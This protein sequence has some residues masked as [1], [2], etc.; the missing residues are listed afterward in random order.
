MTT[1]LTKLHYSQANDKLSFSLDGDPKELSTIAQNFLS[2]TY[3]LP[4]RVKAAFLPVGP[5]NKL[6]ISI[7]HVSKEQALQPNRLSL[8]TPQAKATA[9]LLEELA[10]LCEEDQ[11]KLEIPWLEV[12]PDIQPDTSDPQSIVYAPS[13]KFS[14]DQQKVGGIDDTL[15][16]EA[17]LSALKALFAA[18]VRDYTHEWH[19]EG[20]VS[21]THPS[22]TATSHIKRDELRFTYEYN[23]AFTKQ[24]D[25]GD[26]IDKFIQAMQIANLKPTYFSLNPHTG[27]AVNAVSSAVGTP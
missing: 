14:V 18:H 7:E 8:Q 16:Y 23:A 17:A 20:I 26:A 15:I 13:L 4:Y 21:L 1:A 9:E 24:Q 25:A 19:P 5:Q 10:T 22:G 12:K 3:I 2:N 27:R 6:E 11:V